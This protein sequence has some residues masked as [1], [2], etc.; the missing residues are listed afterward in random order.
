MLEKLRLSALKKTSVDEE[1]DRDVK[2]VPSGA[3]GVKFAVSVSFTIK[4]R[5]RSVLISS[6]PHCSR[7]LWTPEEAAP[8]RAARLQPYTGRAVT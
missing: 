7:A 2:D 8:H 3:K 6:F 4:P 1:R 5:T